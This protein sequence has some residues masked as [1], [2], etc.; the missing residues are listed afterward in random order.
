[1]GLS[2][3][4]SAYYF[5]E[6]DPNFSRLSTIGLMEVRSA[7]QKITDSAAGATAFACGKRSYNGAIGVDVDGNSIPNI[8][9]LLGELSTKTKIGLVSTSSI[10][11]ATPA[12]FYA[13]V[14]KRSM[15]NEIADQM[16][17]S[18][19]DFFAGGGI[20][21]FYRPHLITESFNI[22]TAGNWPEKFDSTNRYGFLWAKDGMPKVHEG[23]GS[24][25]EKATSK[26]LEYLNGPEPFF[27]MV[28]GSQID[29]AGHENDLEY[30]IAEVLD[31]DKA[32]GKAM[33]YASMNENTLVIVTADHE[34]GSFGLSAATIPTEED[35]YESNYDSI[36]P[37]FST[38][39]HSATLIPVLSAGP[40]SE[41]FSGIYR[42]DELGLRIMSVLG[43]DPSNEQ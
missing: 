31:F 24:F 35:P 28:E 4:S 20:E 36:A 10:T 41:L 17:S 37:S 27:L 5:G 43:I 3:L 38:H 1:M 26:A 42:N 7:R 18:A 13:H 39:H 23:R 12:A 30:L 33:D 8:T 11:H 29:W 34:T 21:F 32:V 40:G 25:L 22:D 9:E 16:E 14:E 2:Q 15:E 6:K 19:V